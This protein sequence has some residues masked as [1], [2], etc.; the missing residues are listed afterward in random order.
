MVAAVPGMV[1]A[2]PGMVAVS[3]A[4]RVAAL[5]AASAHTGIAS[6][7]S[8]NGPGGVRV[9]MVGVVGV[10][11]SASGDGAVGSEPAAP[12]ASATAASTSA[13][14]VI[15]GNGGTPSKLGRRVT[16][17]RRPASGELEG[18]VERSAECAAA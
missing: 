3:V 7:G 8:M 2:V 6:A 1:A 4:G 12:A 5:R 9:G 13:D 18:V 11:G 15:G 10:N 17:V 14:G 16:E